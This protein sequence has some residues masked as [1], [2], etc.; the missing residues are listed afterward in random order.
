MSLIFLVRV[1]DE[2]MKYFLMESYFYCQNDKD[3]P[4]NYLTTTYLLLINLILIICTNKYKQ[5]IEY[6]NRVRQYSTPDKVFRYFATIQ[7]P[8]HSGD[9]EVYMTPR[10]FLTSITPGVKQPDG[11]F[12]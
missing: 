10:D 9:Y 12:K 1:F 7:V 11:I 5:I 4:L 6:E 3:T 8:G 2:K